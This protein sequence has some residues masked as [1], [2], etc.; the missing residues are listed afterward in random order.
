MPS[1]ISHIL[2]DY[3]YGVTG[4]VRKRARYRCQKRGVIF[5]DY[6]DKIRAQQRSIG[7][8]LFEERLSFELQ[9][10]NIWTHIEKDTTYSGAYILI[11]ILLGN[12]PIRKRSKYRFKVR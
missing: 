11:P 8:F 10:Q 2:N 3:F 5:L 7:K 9:K 1:L 4:I 12:G 6:N